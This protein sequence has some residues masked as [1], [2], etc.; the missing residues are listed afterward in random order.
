MTTAP[1]IRP[2]ELALA[3]SLYAL[4]GVVVAYLLNYNKSY[5]IAGGVG[6]RTAGLVETAVLLVLVFKFLLGPLSDRFSPFGLGHRRPFIVVGLL[7]QSCG[8]VGLS[9]VHPGVNLA[10]FAA[11]AYLAV[12]GLALYDTCC[13][14]FVIDV[15]PPD[16]RVRVQGLLQVARFLATMLCTWGFGTWMSVTDVGPGKSGGVLWTCAGLGLPPLLMA[17]FIRERVRSAAA[18]S[19]QWSGLKVLLRPRALT[20][21][22]FGALYGIVGL[23]VEFNLSRYYI[24]IGYGQDGVGSFSALR[25]AGRAAGALL[26]PVLKTRLGRRGELVVGLIALAA[27]TAGQSTVA[28]PLSTGGWAFAFGMANGWNDALFCVL[29]MEASDPRMAASTFAVFMA[30]SNVSVLGDA[31]FLE[32][33]HLMHGQYRPV[34][35]GSAVLA[36]GLLAIVPALSSHRSKEDAADVDP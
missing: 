15:T 29:A 20:L 5:M 26:L 4:Q 6:E 3:V 36:I 23:G 27:T 8:L 14:G 33:V 10:G 22:A 19:F 16:D 32:V 18:E 31:I 25:Y 24:H 11:M 34:L 2:A 35:L 7:A 9:V 28:G 1:R 30:I 12:I 13:D 21:L 17:L